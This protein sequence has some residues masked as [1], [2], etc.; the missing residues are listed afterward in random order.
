[1]LK[2]QKYD[3]AFKYSPGKEMV[4]ADTLSRDPLQDIEPDESTSDI[5]KST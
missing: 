5:S 3:I 2:L 1:M 4:I